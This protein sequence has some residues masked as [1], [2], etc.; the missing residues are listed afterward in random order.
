MK[1]IVGSITGDLERGRGKK[2]VSTET[3]VQGYSL[4]LYAVWGHSIVWHLYVQHEY[5]TKSCCS[6]NI[7][8]N[9]IT[10]YNITGLGYLN[11]PSVCK[12]FLFG[13]NHAY[14]SKKIDTI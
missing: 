2:Y 6:Y 3:S 8:L 4:I 12:R 1:N 7:K 9:P 5:N 11:F 13:T 14:I 10:K